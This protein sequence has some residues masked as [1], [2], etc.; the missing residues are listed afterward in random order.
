MN[1]KTIAK[2][3]NLCKKA[4]KET[5]GI[6]IIDESGVL[7]SSGKFAELFSEYEAEPYK[8]WEIRKTTIDGCEFRSFMEVKNNEKTS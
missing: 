7:V 2:L 4:V 1:L 6:L 8:D 5:D 3:S